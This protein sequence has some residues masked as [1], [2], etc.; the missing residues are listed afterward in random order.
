[1]ID[2][3]GT[4]SGD[5]SVQLTSSINIFFVLMVCLGWILI[6]MFLSTYAFGKRD[7]D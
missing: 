5:I 4:L 2:S 1:M 3:I 6:T 7:F